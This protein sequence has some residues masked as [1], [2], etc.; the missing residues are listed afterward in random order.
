M[1]TGARRTKIDREGR[2]AMLRLRLRL[3]SI[4]VSARWA[5]LPLAT[6]AALVASV[7]VGGASPSSGVTAAVAVVTDGDTLRLVERAKGS[8]DSN[9]LPRSWH[10]RVLFTRRSSAPTFIDSTETATDGDASSRLRASLKERLMKTIKRVGAVAAF[11]ATV[12]GTVGRG[13]RPLI[14]TRPPTGAASPHPCSTRT[15]RT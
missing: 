6:G 5:L 8:P 2:E 13:L 15:A 14:C 1:R 11:L 12:S 3:R 7:F 4:D 10:R 9:R